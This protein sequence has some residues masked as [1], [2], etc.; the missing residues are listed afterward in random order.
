MEAATV[1]D[2]L[3]ERGYTLSVQER[4]LQV[5]GPE[6]PPDELDREIVEHRDSLAAR[7]LLSNPPAWLAKLFGLWWNGTETPVRRTNPVTGKAEVYMVS[8]SSREIGTAVAAKIGM[9]P[10]KWEDIREEVE[11]ALGRGEGAA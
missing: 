11:E 2:M 5:R 3:E 4:R 9:D 7:A 1:A 8:V 6:P 10:L